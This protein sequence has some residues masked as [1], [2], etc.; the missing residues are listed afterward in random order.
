[1]LLSFF[2]FLF[3]IILLLDRLQDPYGDRNVTDGSSCNNFRRKWRKERTDCP[4]V[5][6]WGLWMLSSANNEF[7]HSP[8]PPTHV[9]LYSLSYR[10]IRGPAWPL[11]AYCVTSWFSRPL[12]FL[13]MFPKQIQDAHVLIPS[14]NTNA[15]SP[16]NEF[17]WKNF[18]FKFP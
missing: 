18:A 10:S 14:G 11:L 17:Q 5:Q 13:S 1:V 6:S 4:R 15:L 12:F 9:L 2:P 3:F 16:T 8:V 7:F